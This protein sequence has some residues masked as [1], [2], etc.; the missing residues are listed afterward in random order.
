MGTL[1]VRVRVAVAGTAVVIA[2]VLGFQA[3]SANSATFTVNSTLDARDAQAGDGRCATAAGMCTL[4][5]AIQE[6]NALPGADFI[7]VPPGIYELAIAPLNQNDITTGDLDI[8]D[9]VTISG[10]G[11]GSTIVDGGAPPAGSP[12]QVHGLDRLFEVLVDG[13][14]VSFSSLGF[15]DGHAAEYGGA[16]V[17]N[18]TATVTVTDSVL[19]R[20]VAGKAGGAIDNHAG[21]S[22]EVRG[23]SVVDN[24]ASENGSAINNNRD[25]SLTVTD[26]TISSNSAADVGLDEALAGAGAISN[27]ADLDAIGTI[28][29]SGSTMSDNRAGAAVRVRRSRT[30][31]REPSSSTTRRSRRTSLPATA[32]RSPTRRATSPSRTARSPRTPP[33]TAARSTTTARSTAASRS[34][35]RGSR[36]TPRR[37]AAA[38]SRAAARGR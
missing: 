38:L 34:V 27:N 36:S 17:N 22:V 7:Q 15:T 37:P 35:T 14:T 20:N 5:A 19:S 11:A 21:G 12:P 26:S 23:S 30:T 31:V 4:R 9:S 16:I 24:F 28:A 6:A 18:S 13:G 33:M 32:A 29:V 2:T 10:A 1:P 25:G 8:T 3:A